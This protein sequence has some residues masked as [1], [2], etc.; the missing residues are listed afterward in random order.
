MPLSGEQV[1]RQRAHK[2]LERG[3]TSPEG[4]NHPTSEAEPHPEGATGPRARRNLAR[5]G[6]QPPI[7]AEVCLCSAAPL[8]RSGV[9]L[10]GGWA[11]CLVG[12]RGHQSRGPSHWAVSLSQACFR[13]VCVL[14]FTKESGFSLVV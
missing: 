3:R 5:G 6:V 13:F 9:L 4:G 14:F 1:Q 8:E 2:A 12:R 7:E 11:V 10:E